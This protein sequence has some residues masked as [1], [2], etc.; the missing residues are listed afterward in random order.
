MEWINTFPS[1]YKEQAIDFAK[2]DPEYNN[3]DYHVI[4]Y[5]N[6]ISALTSAFQFSHCLGY[7]YWEN[8]INDNL[9]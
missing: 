8:F 7:Q 9:R 3:H 6:P 5:N 1:P 4:R 2:Q